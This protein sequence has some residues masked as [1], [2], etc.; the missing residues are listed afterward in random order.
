MVSFIRN[1][2]KTLNTA[3]LKTLQIAITFL[4]LSGLNACSSDN[5]KVTASS[6]TVENSPQLLQY[7]PIEE[8]LVGRWEAEHEENTLVFLFT[9]DQRVIMWE[10]GDTQASDYGK[11]SLETKGYLKILNVTIKDQ[12]V[13]L[14]ALKFPDEETMRYQRSYSSALSNI[15]AFKSFNRNAIYFKKFLIQI[16]SHLTCH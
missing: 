12:V 8:Q 2:H 9:S 15:Y 11:Y 6:P 1:D 14:G 7:V 10:V 4:L 16:S 5:Q 3:C 13:S